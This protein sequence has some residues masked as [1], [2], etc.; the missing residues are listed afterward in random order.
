[1]EWKAEFEKRIALLESKIRELDRERN[2]AEIK[3]SQLG[4][5][6]TEYVREISKLQAEA[7]VMFLLTHI[8]F[9]FLL[10][11]S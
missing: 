5:T 9:F 8:Y 10:F 11:L 4:L 3:S 1:M 2:D 7:E 6:I